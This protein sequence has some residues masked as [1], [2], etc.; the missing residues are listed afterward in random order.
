VIPVAFQSSRGGR[1]FPG[2]HQRATF[3]VAEN[4]QQID[5]HMRSADGRV[6][7]KIVG[8]A[9]ERLAETSAFGSVSEASAFFE[10]GSVGYSVT[11][12]GRRLD[13]IVLT[14]D[15]WSVAPLAIERAYSSYFSDQEMFPAGS[16]D[17]DCALVMR[18]VTHEW[19]TVPDLV[20]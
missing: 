12:S 17:F 8:Q 18:N 14:T 16:I 15:S 6:E 5:L 2:E 3:E 7:I 1:F 9:A 20:L 4:E 11:A 13:G 10:S 19:E